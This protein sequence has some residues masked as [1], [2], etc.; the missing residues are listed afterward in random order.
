[1]NITSLTMEITDA[2]NLECSHCY[3]NSG[4]LDDSQEMDI[5]TIRL[6][7]I[8]LWKFNKGQ[9]DEIW[10]SGGE[11]L[12]HSK[13]QDIVAL[14]VSFGQKPVVA[15]NGFY[16]DALLAKLVNASANIRRVHLSLEGI[17]KTN[18]SVRGKG[19]FEHIINNIIPA[20]KK[21]GFHVCVT[22]H[23]RKANYLEVQELVDLV[24]DRLDCDIKFGIIR[25]VGRAKKNLVPDM[26]TPKDLYE[27]ISQIY[28]LKKRYKTKRIWHDWDI[29]T[30]DIKFYTQN[31]QGKDCCPAGLQTTIT[32]TNDFDIY[33]CSQLRDSNFRLGNFCKESNLKDILCSSNSQKIC[34][35]LATKSS[36]C[37]GCEYYKT[38][39][40]GGCPAVAYGLSNSIKDISAL[41]PYCFSGLVAKKVCSRFV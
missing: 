40:Q 11:P 28:N 31:Y 14:L 16:N 27:C 22:T 13:F 18:D 12:L 24:V 3:N 4:V 5:E 26:L 33:P 29:F 19:T 36:E 37:L 2:C 23:L 32:C 7:L 25:P 41:D 6:F 39:C 10:L 30:N 34:N 17:G 20:L 21:R 35:L 1:M 38:S 8:E 15:T 9:L